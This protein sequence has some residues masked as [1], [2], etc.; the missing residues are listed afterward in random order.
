MSTY[1]LAILSAVGIWLLGIYIA[2]RNYE[3]VY[4]EIPEHFRIGCAT[5]LDLFLGHFP[6]KY[7]NCRCKSLKWAY[8]GVVFARSILPFP[9]FAVTLWVSW[10]FNRAAT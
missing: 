5:P 9:A 3:R 10:L 7:V 6:G 2:I 1:N 8:R 4:D